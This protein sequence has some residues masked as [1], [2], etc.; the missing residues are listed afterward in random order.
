MIKKDFN[1]FLFGIVVPSLLAVGLFITSIYVIIIPS[2]ER[3]MMEKK[4]D[5]INEL[6]NT[7]WSLVNEYNEE[8]F[9]NETSIIL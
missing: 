1:K 2:F 3:N 9:C 7:A 4:K 5:M 6:T 8:L